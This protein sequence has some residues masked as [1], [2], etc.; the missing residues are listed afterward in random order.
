M[1]AVI[2][3]PKGS[4]CLNCQHRE[5]DCSAFNFARMKVSKQYSNKTDPTVFKVVI[6]DEFKAVKL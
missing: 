6:C 5:N 3:H 2:H 4:M 1:S